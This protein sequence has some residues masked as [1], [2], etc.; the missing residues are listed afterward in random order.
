MFTHMPS[1]EEQSHL[2]NTVQSPPLLLFLPALAVKTPLFPLDSLYGNRNHRTRS[3]FSCL[4]A[5]FSGS[6]TNEKYRQQQQ[7][8]ADQRRDT[9]ERKYQVTHTCRQ[10]LSR[11]APGV[12]LFTNYF[13]YVAQSVFVKQKLA[14]VQTGFQIFELM[15]SVVYG[16]FRGIAVKFFRVLMA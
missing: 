10:K 4:P 15:L 3:L 14:C 7:L 2:T 8:S 11:L 16:R 1:H 5:G 13:K 9:K 6:R 12:N